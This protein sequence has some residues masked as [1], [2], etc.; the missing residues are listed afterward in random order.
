LLGLGGEKKSGNVTG[1][2]VRMEGRARA[3]GDGGGVGR[4]PVGRAKK[5]V[6]GV[7]PRPQKS[8]A[9]VLVRAPEGGT[10]NRGEW[11]GPGK[12]GNIA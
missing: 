1:G 5:W 4:G 10:G 8:R 6:G 3:E 12:K 2:F 9:I 7:Q 11:D